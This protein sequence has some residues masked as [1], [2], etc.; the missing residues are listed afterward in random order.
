VTRLKTG[1]YT[2][3]ELCARAQ[4][5]AR[6]QGPAWETIQAAIRVWQPHI[7]GTIDII[8]RGMPT[9]LGE[10]GVRS[11]LEGKRE[12]LAAVEELAETRP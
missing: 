11:S 2:I 1:R 12:L 3:S 7:A 5:V 6:G 4:F 10:E 8:L 9:G